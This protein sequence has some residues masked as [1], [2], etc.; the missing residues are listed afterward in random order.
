MAAVACAYARAM[1]S[2]P[3]FL[4]VNHAGELGFEPEPTTPSIPESPTD[5][6]KYAF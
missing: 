6:L 1:G 3:N 2:Q 4:P 5:G